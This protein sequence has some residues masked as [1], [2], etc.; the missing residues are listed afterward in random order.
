MGELSWF[1][2]YVVIY[3]G[4]TGHQFWVQ[5]EGCLAKSSSNLSFVT[6]AVMRT[7]D[8]F[9]AKA[10]QRD[11]AYFEVQERGKATALHN[12]LSSF[13]LHDCVLFCHAI[14]TLALRRWPFIVLCDDVHAMARE[15]NK[16]N[17]D[18]ALSLRV[19][20]TARKIGS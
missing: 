8:L 19:S 4:D 17:W 10:V 13:F 11:S 1:V 12:F 9:L 3:C 5:D 14:G 20:G 6:G 7:C 15:K 16:E 18:F 2:A